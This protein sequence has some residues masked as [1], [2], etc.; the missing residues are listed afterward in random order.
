M[1]I[2]DKVKYNKNFLQSLGSTFTK[3]EFKEF[4]AIGE[5]TAIKN[6]YD[7]VSLCTVR[8]PHGDKKILNT[9][10]VKYSEKEKLFLDKE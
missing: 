8:F 4:N 1:K 9:K 10:L 2:G 5:I 6:V 7:K 3:E